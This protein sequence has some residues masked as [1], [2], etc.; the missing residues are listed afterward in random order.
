NYDFSARPGSEV[1]P[2]FGGLHLLLAQDSTPLPDSHGIQDVTLARLIKVVEQD[3]HLQTHVDRFAMFVEPRE[4]MAIQATLGS[5]IVMLFDEWPPH[6]CSYDDAAD[7]LKRT[8]RWA[9]KCKEVPTPGLKFGIVQGSAYADLRMESAEA[10]AAMD[11]PGYA[12][13]GVS[14]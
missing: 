1:L 4:L 2:H 14:V 6:P 9:A 13:G 8:L 10:L 7:S 11:F 12:I 5:D 3:V